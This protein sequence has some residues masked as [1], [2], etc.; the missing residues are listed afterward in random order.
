MYA[1]GQKSSVL[2]ISVLKCRHLPQAKRR[3]TSV[4]TGLKVGE[5]LDNEHGKVLVSNF[6]T[7]TELTKDE[8]YEL[9]HSLSLSDVMSLFGGFSNI[10]FECLDLNE[11]DDEVETEIHSSENPK[12]NAF[13]ILVERNLRFQKKKYQKQ[14]TN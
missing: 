8:R 11:T 12:T 10:S 14:G 4:D 9:E 3:I 13:P 2:K 5:L 1:A 7:W 6:K